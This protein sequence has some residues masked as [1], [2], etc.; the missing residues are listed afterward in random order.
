MSFVSVAAGV[1]TVVWHS[2]EVYALHS[3][4][5]LYLIV[6]LLQSIS[7]ISPIVGLCKYHI[8]FISPMLGSEHAPNLVFIQI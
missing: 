2:F 6:F 5:R 4:V 1:A 3:G 7:L 8:G